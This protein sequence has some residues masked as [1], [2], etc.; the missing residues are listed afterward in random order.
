MSKGKGEITRVYG[1]LVV[2][3]GVANAKIGDVVQL[4]PLK[5]IGEIIRIRGNEVS[6]QCYED[7]SG[8]KPGDEIL[9]TE[10][11]L[12]A[13][14]GPGLIGSIFD[15]LEFSE[16]EIR[17]LIGDFMKKGVRTAPL[18]RY[19]K[20]HFTPKVKV[21]DKVVEGD[22]IGT[23]PE[24]LMVEHR[25]L[26]PVGL[27]G[28]IRE[29]KEGDFT[30]TD[31]IATL[32]S[33]GKKVDL[34]M[35]QLWPI[36][37]PRPY[38]GRL[39]LTEPLL[40]GQRVIDSFF[41]IAKGGTAAI[42]GGFGTGKCVLPGTPVLLA[43]GRLIPIEELFSK[44]DVG[45]K[46]GD[47]EE[48]RACNFNVISF[49][50]F[51][52]VEK[53]ASHVY[54]GWTDRIIKLSTS[55]GRK[56]SVTPSHE[57]IV[58]NPL[59]FFEERA[60]EKVKV[61]DYIALPR[62]IPLNLEYQ[63]L[64]P[65]TLGLRVRDGKVLRKVKSIIKALSKRLGGMEKLANLLGVS[66]YVLSEIY[67][68][69]NKPLCQIV[70]KLFDLIGEFKP[71][72]RYVGIERSKNKLKIPRVVDE[73]FAEFLGLLLS[74]GMIAGRAI[75]LFND[76]PLILKR[77]AEIASRLFG[78]KCVKKSFRTVSG[79]AI[80]NSALIRLL[81]AIGYPER[82]K[83]QNVT[84]PEII[85][86]SPD[87]VVAA[88][89]KGYYLGDGCFSSGV[90]GISS[91]SSKFVH[92]LSYILSRL[93]ILYSVRGDRII[94]S[95][96][97]ELAKFLKIFDER[98]LK[99]KKVYE[100]KSYLN[101]ERKESQVRD[102]VPLDAELMKDI[103]VEI[104]RKRLE[105]ESIFI[106]N[107]SELGERMGVA[108]LSKMVTRV[109]GWSSLERLRTL[110]SV[111]EYI[112]LERVEAKDVVHGEFT[113]YD[114]TVPETHNFIGGETPLILHNTVTLHQIA[115]WAAAD[116]ILYIGCGERGNEMADAVTHFPQLEDPRSGKKLIERTIMIA[117]V[118]NMPVS[119]REASI[120]MGVTIA[121]YFR[122]QGYDVA[123]M[124]DSTS[125]WAEA[126]R[127]I[128]G[129]LEEIPAEAGYPA[130]LPERIAEFYERAGRVITLGSEYRVGSVTIMGAVSP[131]GGD[132]SEPVTSITL[133]FV[134]T[135]WA[136]DTALAFRRHFPAINWL[137][138]FSRYVELVSQWWQT[139]DKDWLKYK[140]KA[141]AILEEASKIEEIA[142]IIGEK[143]LPDAQ[144]L[145]LL[146]A[147]MIRE[148]FLVQHAFHEVDTYCEP[149]K[150]SKL[151]RT[152]VEF[153]E[154]T[155]PLIRA[156]VPV[157]KI[158]EFKSIVELMRL[159]ERKGVEHIDRAKNDV[160][161]EVKAL[162][163]QY[164]VVI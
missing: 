49:D 112:V 96:C 158:R 15:G 144:R 125:R 156:G 47:K 122:D 38:K 155:E 89:L 66:P 109:Q 128:S 113:V 107:Y 149:E 132:F 98:S 80:Y 143:A 104:G 121:E 115:K 99:I 63:K 97:K 163:K 135:L 84:I 88:F 54:K 1:S 62:K 48:L 123:I 117:N 142:R 72:I 146:V 147:E 6:I 50:G 29:I 138:S 19:K 23:T 33:D 140:M 59:G 61:G 20:W 139:Y 14:L 53:R 24:S 55:S 148:G 77:F 73:E 5:L 52:L 46:V 76:D 105:G 85:Q 101:L 152:L 65:Y 130:Y 2:G 133:R 8:L 22:I 131:P 111:L 120:Y 153:Y 69:R 110:A 78:V 164:G 124:A 103:A 60:A 141:T 79:L 81:K 119:A 67:S 57:V 127:D 145:I 30:V 83:S 10:R 44:A 71:V 58:F 129:R 36:R 40:T 93:G 118:S 42:P 102:I 70:A 157:E 91:A 150:Q 12:I 32:E 160:L 151:L 161:E 126:L 162:A 92:Q 51:K 35:M 137:M 25:I 159:K 31:S 86:R 74:D 3:K 45:E 154:L 95:S 11:P 39:P 21:G 94:I 64:D 106:R 68:G 34:T 4:G 134:G 136:L 41:P 28:V 116:I 9:N 7:T 13:E 82:K 27:R 17:S 16:S 90:V 114:L 18:N 100:I 108:L 87:S 26:V 75:H 37:I 43:D 56:L